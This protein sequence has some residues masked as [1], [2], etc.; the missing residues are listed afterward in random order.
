MVAT[1]RVDICQLCYYCM[2]PVLVLQRGDLLGVGVGMGVGN[3]ANEQAPAG[4]AKKVVAESVVAKG[5][6]GWGCGVGA[7][8]Q[9]LYAAV[10]RHLLCT[11][12]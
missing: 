12:I 11:R 10:P 2:K 6:M 1:W 8:R 9:R 3:L 5:K 7:C 4:R